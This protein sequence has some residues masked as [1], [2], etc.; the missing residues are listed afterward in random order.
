[1]PYDIKTFKD[2]VFCDISPIEFCDVL[3]GQICLWKRHDVYDSR[4]RSVI[5]TLDRQLYMIPELTP[6]TAISLISIE[7]CSKVIS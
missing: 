7:Q 4:P 5:I 1:M 6:P 3:L 2:K